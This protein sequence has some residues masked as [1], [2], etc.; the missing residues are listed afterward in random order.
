M[1]WGFSRCLGSDRVL[2]DDGIGGGGFSGV[3]RFRVV[4]KFVSVL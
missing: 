4:S 3:G 2:V 1:C